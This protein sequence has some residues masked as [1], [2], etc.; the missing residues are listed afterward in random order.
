MTRRFDGDRVGG[1]QDAGGLRVDH[2][3]DDDPHL[4][5]ALVDAVAQPVGH[6]ALGEQRGP[7][8]G[9]TYCEDC[10]GPAMFMYESCWP[11]NEADGSVLG[12]GARAHG[13][14]GLVVELRKRAGDLGP[15][16]VRDPR[17]AG[18][19]SRTSALILRIASR[20]SGVQE[21]QRIEPTADSR[22][23][24]QDAPEGGRGQAEAWGHLDAVDARE[25]TQLRALAAHERRLR[26]VD[27][28][29]SNHQM[30]LDAHGVA[31][32]SSC[33]GRLCG[34]P[35]GLKQAP[36]VAILWM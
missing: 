19:A 20:S 3:L 32:S 1:E 7:V 10:V 13:V 9:R 36:L 4:C 18:S 35:R 31:P 12:R 6:G 25:R 34:T 11:A 2:P 14:D 8:P 26:L 17:G 27:L 21:R 24:R 30:L 23:S 33:G 16:P 5:A 28:V 15:E 22:G 29:D